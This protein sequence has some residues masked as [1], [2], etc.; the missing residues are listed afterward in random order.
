MNKNL[1]YQFYIR[2][3]NY[4]LCHPMLKLVKI[5]IFISVDEKLKIKI[6][7]I[8]PN[9]KLSSKSSVSRI[10]VTQKLKKFSKNTTLTDRALSTKRSAKNSSPIS[11]QIFSE[12]LEIKSLYY[13]NSTESTL[14]Y[15]M[16]YWNKI[17]I[18]IP[19]QILQGREELLCSLTDVRKFGRFQG[20]IVRLVAASVE[21]AQQST[22][23]LIRK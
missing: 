6:L 5:K 1:S 17:I 4:S 9:Q 11:C 13:R 23:H 18:F 19:V 12:L 21:A 7:K 16:I 20:S 2:F 15:T 8:W 14:N 10:W 22:F 3:L